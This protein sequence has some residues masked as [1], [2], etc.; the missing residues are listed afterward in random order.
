[1]RHAVDP[2][3][4]PSPLSFEGRDRFLVTLVVRERLLAI[5][6][7]RLEH[8]PI[9]DRE[10]DRGVAWRRVGVLMQ[11]PR[12]QCDDVATS[13]REAHAVDDGLA[14]SL[15]H[16]VDRTA[17]VTMGLEPRARTEH[18]DPAGHRW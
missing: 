18:L 8:W 13:P 6:T 12:R 17:G 11:G 15:H 1:C 5:E 16:V 4:D 10:Q 9:L 7:E 14:R 2:F 3:A